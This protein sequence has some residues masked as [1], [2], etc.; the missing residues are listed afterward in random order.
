MFLEIERKMKN[1]ENVS[2]EL[3]RVIFE[4]L[5]RKISVQ[6]IINSMSKILPDCT[7]IPSTLL[8]ILFENVNPEFRALLQIFFN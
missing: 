2:G 7:F 5:K 8:C 3:F 1:K 4:F 6:E